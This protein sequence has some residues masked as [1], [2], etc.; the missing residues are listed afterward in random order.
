MQR[1]AVSAV[2][3][4]RVQKEGCGINRSLLF[5]SNVIQ[6]LGEQQE[7]Q[8]Q[9]PP[10]S[11]P[12]HSQHIPYRSCILTRILE[13]ALGGNSRTAII[14]CVSESCAH[15]D[16]SLRT[17]R[18]AATAKHIS[19]HARVNAVPDAKTDRIAFLEARLREAETQE[20]KWRT[21]FHK[22]SNGVG[23]SNRRSD[24]QQQLEL[25]GDRG[26]AQTECEDEG[27]EDELGRTQ[28]Q[29]RIARLSRLLSD[30]RSEMIACK[31]DII[32]STNTILRD[33]QHSASRWQQLRD[34]ARR[35]HRQEMEILQALVRQSSAANSEVILKCLALSAPPLH[36]LY[37]R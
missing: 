1:S 16:E 33:V 14:A 9:Q 15:S 34:D 35:Q 37:A 19:T 25:E 18:F 13:P 3:G 6:K 22:L 36:P 29:Q 26:N 24:T 28:Q 31:T 8:Q 10:S 4:A 20:R 21:K 23:C 5:L 32:L 30:V 11:P 12:S 27:D 17:L 7:R 2:S